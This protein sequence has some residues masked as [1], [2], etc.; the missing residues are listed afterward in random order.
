MLDHTDFFF[1]ISCNLPRRFGQAHEPPI[2]VDSRPTM[3]SV[4]EPLVQNRSFL[5]GISLARGGPHTE[6][7]TPSH[8]NGRIDLPSLPPDWPTSS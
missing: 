3:P 8:Q 5:A 7:A 1:Q 4:R 2:R 6:P